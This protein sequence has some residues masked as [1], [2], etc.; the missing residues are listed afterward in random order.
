[1]KTHYDALQLREIF[2]LEFLRWFG[3]K[4]KADQYVL[5][6]GANLRFFFNS[7]RYSEDIDLDV[8]DIAK[9][10]LADRV[11]QILGSPSF[12]EALRTYGI[13]GVVPPDLAR[14]KQT[15]TTQRFKVHLLTVAGEDLFSKVEFSRRG[16]R[17]ETA[18]QA[19]HDQVM[20][21]Y[22]ASP[23]LVPHYVLYAAIEQKIEA[24]CTRTIIQ[25]RDVFDLY[26]LSPHYRRSEA[27]VLPVEGARLDK[28][29]DNVFEID[30]AQFRDT[31]VAYLS[32]EDR[33]VYDNE[34]AWDEIRMRVSDFIGELERGHGA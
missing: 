11:M 13:R 16:F 25:A 21:S 24:L 1:M 14:A 12:H 2:H 20:R 18:V 32:H 7:I 5:K 27:G 26:T 10:V 23:L 4:T 3:K 30:F 6:G 15:E 34:A 8:R 31:V 28:A 9:E 17:G 33:A 22:A 29:R 19:V